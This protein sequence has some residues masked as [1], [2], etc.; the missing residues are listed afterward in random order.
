MRLNRYLAACGLTSRR[1][2]EN[3]IRSGRV[4]ING[5]IVCEF[6][7]IVNEND[8]VCV[9]G[10]QVVPEK[11]VYIVMNKPRGVVC[12]VEDPFDRTVIELLPK[13]Y[14]EVR[15]FPV[16]RL[17]KESE[18]LLV[19]SNDGD[20]AHFLMHPSSN[21]PKS[22]EIFLNKKVSERDLVSWRKGVTIEGGFVRPLLVKVLKREPLGMWLF[23]QIGEGLKREIRLM[24]EKLGFR[25]R[26]LIRRRIGRM[27]LRN[28]KTGHIVKLSQDVLL[29]KIQ[30]GGFV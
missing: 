7:I 26:V 18:G 20:F 28:L 23:I 6:S 25:V 3:L 16:G 17:D 15:V 8:V 2:A 27:E 13:E 1:K 22:Y 11:K 10:T 29:K 21:I 30:Q 14:E 9:D 4:S 12:A 5:E 19:L 24:A